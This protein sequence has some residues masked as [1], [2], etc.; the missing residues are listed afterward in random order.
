MWLTS[1]EGELI[2]YCSHG[3]LSPCLQKN[4]PTERGG[5]NLLISPDQIEETQMPPMGWMALTW[6]A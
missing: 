4:A 5:Y 3:A 6:P 1:P 2:R